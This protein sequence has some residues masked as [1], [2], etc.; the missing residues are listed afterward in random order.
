MSDSTQE[1]LR[2]SPPTKRSIFRDEAVRR[3]VE[4]Q[5]K[6]VLPRLL[7]PKTFFYL[8]LL[9]GLIAATSVITWLAI[10]PVTDLNNERISSHTKN[11]LQN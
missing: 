11:L 2:D 6:A 5:E 8:W 3:Y 7:S 10:E 1:T 4:S 9:V